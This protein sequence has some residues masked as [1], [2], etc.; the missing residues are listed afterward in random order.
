MDK[1]AVIDGE[2]YCGECGEQLPTYSARAGQCSCG[3][4][5]WWSDDGGNHGV[6][7]PVAADRVA[8]QVLQRLVRPSAEFYE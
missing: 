3:R 1:V 7:R 8:G 5:A 6:E 2:A 4:F